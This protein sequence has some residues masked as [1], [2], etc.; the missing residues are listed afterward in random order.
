MPKRS[1]LPEAEAA[2]FSGGAESIKESKGLGDLLTDSK[3]GSAR[4]L[5]LASKESKSGAGC[6]V[7]VGGCGCG[8]F[9]ASCTISGNPLASGKGFTEGIGESPKGPGGTG[10]GCILG[11]GGIGGGGRPGKGFL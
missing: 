10:E 1:E 6:C 5:N 2:E 3:L 7:I 11:A 4:L 9:G 8:G